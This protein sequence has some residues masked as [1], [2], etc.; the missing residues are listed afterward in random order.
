MVKSVANLF[1]RSSPA[2][3]ADPSGWVDDIVVAAVEQ[4]RFVSMIVEALIENI[5]LRMRAGD[6]FGE[7]AASHSKACR[8]T[9]RSSACSSRTHDRTETA[10]H[11]PQILLQVPPSL[12]QRLQ[13][14][15]LLEDYFSDE[16]CTRTPR[17]Y[18][19]SRRFGANT[20]RTFESKLSKRRAAIAFGPAA[21]SAQ[22]RTLIRHPRQ[23]GEGPR[24]D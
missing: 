14:A 11:L 5:I 1:R 4:R 19:S 8:A 24:T 22:G 13:F 2:V 9:Q 23:D 17:R 12:A 10:W 3:S 16:E 18:A 20:D 6:G 15:K 7:T 21:Q